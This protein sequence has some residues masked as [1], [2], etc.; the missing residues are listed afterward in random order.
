[1]A[2]AELVCE[3]IKGCHTDAMSRL[4]GHVRAW[5]EQDARI[6]RDRLQQPAPTPQSRND[7]PK[8]AD[9]QPATNAAEGGNDGWFRRVQP[10]VGAANLDAD[11]EVWVRGDAEY[12][13]DGAEFL[14]HLV[15]IL[16]SREVDL[17]LF[18]DRQRVNKRM[19]EGLGQT[20]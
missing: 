16:A 4:E 3:T 6:A 2:A 10:G 14:G 7:I 17:L 13:F 12:T 1:M 18:E 15:E 20:E 9:T 8:E 5:M 19:A 11:E